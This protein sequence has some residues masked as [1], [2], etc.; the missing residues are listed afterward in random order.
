MGTPIAID[1]IEMIVTIGGI[2]VAIGRIAID[3]T[4]TG[5]IDMIGIMSGLEEVVGGIE[6]KV[7]SDGDGV[8]LRRAGTGIGRGIDRAK[9]HTE[10]GRGTRNVPSGICRWRLN[11][12][13]RI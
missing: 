7:A 3:R 4:V 11:R 6:A 12:S 9:G 13:C 2:E 5:E 1:T 10:I 8:D